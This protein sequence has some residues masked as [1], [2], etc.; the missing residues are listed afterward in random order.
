MGRREG[1]LVE[2]A[3]EQQ[4]KLKAF[5]APLEIDLWG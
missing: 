3:E 4:K 2:E 5:Q 1:L